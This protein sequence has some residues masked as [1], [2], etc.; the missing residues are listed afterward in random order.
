H[1]SRFGNVSAGQHV[2]ARQLIGYV[3][4]TGRATGPHL[5]FAV[6]RVNAAG[7]EQFIDPLSMR[8]DGVRIIPPRLRGDFDEVKKTLDAE[9]DS[10]TLPDAPPPSP[11]DT[12]ATEKPNEDP[13][14]TE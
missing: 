9:I 1:L 7:I 2:E 3:G 5:P 4:Q 12:S 8:L 10:I 13:A 11:L 14:E 6:K